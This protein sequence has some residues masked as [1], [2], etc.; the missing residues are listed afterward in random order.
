M[1]KHDDQNCKRR[2]RGF[3]SC[4]GKRVRVVVVVGQR[5]ARAV[6]SH[7]PPLHGRARGG[8]DVR[9]CGWGLA[10]HRYVDGP[11]IGHRI[12]CRSGLP[13]HLVYGAG[14]VLC[15]GCRI[16]EAPRAHPSDLG[17]HRA[18]HSVM[19]R[20]CL[21]ETRRPSVKETAGASTWEQVRTPVGCTEGGLARRNRRD[22][23][24]PVPW[25]SAVRRRGR[26]RGTRAG[27]VS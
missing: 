10:R 20:R 5:P 26:W 27:P 3:S 21:G 15:R 13:S 9:G 8:P 14:I 11:S 16:V 24:V 18:L 25:V 12:R 2:V 23:E 17:D 1:G 4:R 6:D 7:P 19:G 22:L